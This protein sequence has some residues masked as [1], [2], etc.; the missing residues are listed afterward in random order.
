[1][2]VVVGR[3]GL[4]ENDELDRPAG[5]IAVA[6]AAAGAQVELV[7]SIGD[8]PAGD[9]VVLALG[10]AAI[11]HAALLRDPAA[12]TSCAA[13]PVG[14]LPRLDGPDVELGLAYLAD[15]EVLVVAEPLPPAAI[16]AA[17][18]AAEFQGAA[19]I[20]VVGA[21]ERPPTGLPPSA[22]VLEMPAG[23]YRAFANLVGTY[24]A[25]LDD[26]LEPARAWEEAVKES[27]W[28]AS[29]EPAP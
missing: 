11:G 6:A 20:V 27:G 24:A 26:G 16:D 12:V 28:S 23:D 4:D 7:G 2:I 21:D 1:M 13:G 17:R 18:K 29:G 3:P 19:L 14:P 22:T 25:N 10:Q 5:L 9:R 8:D 15:Y